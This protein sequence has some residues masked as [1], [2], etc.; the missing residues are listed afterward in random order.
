M[1]RPVLISMFLQ[2][3]RV[4]SSKPWLT[5]YIFFSLMVIS[6]ILFSVLDLD[7]SDLC[8]FSRPLEKASIVAVVPLET[9]FFKSPELVKPH[10]NPMLPVIEWSDKFSWKQHAM[11]LSFSQL[12]MPRSHGCR[13]SL[14]RNSLSPASDISPL[15]D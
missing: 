15:P 11:L 5:A 4:R 3:P 1:R 9:E 13:A 7:G 14:A 10:D 12:H 2:L 8:R 6:Y